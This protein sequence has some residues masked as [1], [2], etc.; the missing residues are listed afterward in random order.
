[1]AEQ[2]AI[3]D[4]APDNLTCDSGDSI[5]DE[6]SRIEDLAL[7]SHLT[8]NQVKDRMPFYERQMLYTIMAEIERDSD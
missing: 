7:A 1:M 8:L 2:S 6:A 5:Y 3:T 4:P